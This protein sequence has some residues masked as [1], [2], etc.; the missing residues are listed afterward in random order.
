MPL[1]AFAQT[2]PSP[3]PSGKPSDQ[4]APITLSPFEVRAEDDGSY[5]AT[6]TLAGTRFNSEL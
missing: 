4:E 1:V 2:V 6:H 5:L 3:A